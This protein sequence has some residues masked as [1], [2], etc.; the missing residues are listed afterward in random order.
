M[1]KMRGNMCY[2]RLGLRWS[3]R[4]ETVAWTAIRALTGQ[5]SKY[6]HIIY[7]QAMICSGFTLLGRVLHTSTIQSTSLATKGPALMPSQSAMACSTLSHVSFPSKNSRLFYTWCKIW[8][9]NTRSRSC[10]VIFLLCR[11]TWLHIE[12]RFFPVPSA[13]HAP[14]KVSRRFLASPKQPNKNSSSEYP[15]ANIITPREN[16]SL[17]FRSWTSRVRLW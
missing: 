9:F 7:Q 5:F 16:L 6:I 10:F 11:G 1:R 3:Q 8:R 4:P 15:T 13:L 17:N 14:P 2:V 12:V